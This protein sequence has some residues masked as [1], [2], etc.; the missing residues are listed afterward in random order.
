M[1]LEEAY[2][3]CAIEHYS[4]ATLQPGGDVTV[5]EGGAW[6]TM[7]LFIPSWIL[8]DGFKVGPREEWEI[9]ADPE[10]VER[11]SEHPGVYALWD[12]ANPEHPT[13]VDQL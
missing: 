4:T 6:V 2:R 7:R 13:F 12:P 3:S 1:T 5:V 11:L 8:G 10:D 9:D